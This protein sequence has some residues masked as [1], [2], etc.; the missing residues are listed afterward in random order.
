MTAKPPP[1]EFAST[2]A[3]RVTARPPEDPRIAA[4]QHL[5]DQ[6]LIHTAPL[7]HEHTDARDRRRLAAE[8]LPFGARLKVT[9]NLRPARSRLGP[10]AEILLGGVTAPAL[11]STAGSAVFG[12]T[13]PAD[14]LGSTLD[15]TPLPVDRATGEPA[16]DAEVRRL[17]H[18]LEATGQ[19]EASTKVR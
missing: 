6:A 10:V 15:A 12:R 18:R 19:L 2:K 17:T 5:L 13:Q 11:S 9:S 3:P 16:V 7:S 1:V 14:Q 4:A 8:P